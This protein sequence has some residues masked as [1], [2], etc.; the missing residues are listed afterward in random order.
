MFIADDTRS[1][2]YSRVYDGRHCSRIFLFVWIFYAA[3]CRVRVFGKIWVF[4]WYKNFNG[5]VRGLESMEWLSEMRNSLIEWIACWE[6][7]LMIGGCLDYWW[8]C[9]G[10]LVTG[11]KLSQKFAK[12]I[13][14]KVLERFKKLH[15]ILDFFMFILQCNNT[16]IRQIVMIFAESNK[17]FHMW[18]HV[19]SRIIYHQNWR[20][21][22]TFADYKL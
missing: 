8:S 12:N 1:S 21:Y 15:K 6:M 2:V 20:G 17:N 18:T 9:G 14:L 22:D 3:R 13:Y 19:G 5:W 10:I 16:A 4:A 7:G 11:A